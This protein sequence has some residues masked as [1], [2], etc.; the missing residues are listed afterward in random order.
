MNDKQRELIIAFG[1]AGFI[2]VFEVRGEDVRIGAM[3]HQLE[4][5]GWRGR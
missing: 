4:P 2:A 1:S 3:R 5:E